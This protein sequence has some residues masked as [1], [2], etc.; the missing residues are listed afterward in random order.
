MGGAAL[1]QV[2]RILGTAGASI[3]VLAGATFFLQGMGVLPGS[4]M[5]GDRVWAVIGAAMM[6]GGIVMWRRFTR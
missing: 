5:S 6:F 2:S 1:A 3:A 4:V